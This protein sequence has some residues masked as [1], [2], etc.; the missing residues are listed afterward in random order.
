MPDNK[1]TKITSFAQKSRSQELG[2]A[3]QRMGSLCSMM[4]EVS[5][6]IILMVGAGPPVSPLP[7]VSLLAHTAFPKGEPEHPQNTQPQ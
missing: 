1:Q 2:Q 7:L 4:S 5:A 3:T 6:G